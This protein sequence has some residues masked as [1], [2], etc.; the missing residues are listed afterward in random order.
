MIC[1]QTNSKNSF[2]FCATNLTALQSTSLF[3]LAAFQPTDFAVLYMIYICLKYINLLS[4]LKF[5]YIILISC[6][7]FNA[8][9]Y[10]VVKVL[11]SF[12][13]NQW[14]CVGALFA[15]YEN[16]NQTILFVGR[17][18]TSDLKHRCA[19]YIRHSLKRSER[20]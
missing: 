13:Y 8:K 3:R 10:L 5:N 17:Y 20:K 2:R 16:I 7:C 4:Y 19:L 12:K 9:L 6:V 15:N 1:S 14:F 18:L 11:C